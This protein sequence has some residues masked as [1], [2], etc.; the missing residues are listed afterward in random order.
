M[1]TFNREVP[2]FSLAGTASVLP[3]TFM[4][5]HR[6]LG[7]LSSTRIAS[8]RIISNSIFTII[9]PLH[10]TDYQLLTAFPCWSQ[11]PRGL[12]HEPSSPAQTLGSWVRI[13]LEALMSVWVYFVFVLFCLQIA[14]LRGAD[15]PSKES[16]RLCKWS[17]NWKKAKAQQ[18]A[19]EPEIDSVSVDTEISGR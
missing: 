15:P 10:F 6:P 17:R 11:W 5:S 2:G 18:R 9:Q 12:R 14:A 16:Y 8:F 13:P 4:V 7:E 1:M 3:E 19:V